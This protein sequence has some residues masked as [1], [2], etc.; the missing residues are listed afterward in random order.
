MKKRLLSLMLAVMM[1]LSILPAG[2]SA[3]TTMTGL[4]GAPA[5]PE[6]RMYV[7]QTYGNGDEE[8]HVTNNWATPLHDPWEARF[9]MYYPDGSTKEIHPDNMSRTSEVDYEGK[10]SAD[11][12][13]H[14]GAKVGPGIIEYEEVNAYTKGQKETYRVNVEI[15]LPELGVYD[16][17]PFNADSLVDPV[18]VSDTNNIFY[19]ALSPNMKAAGS[20][21]KEFVVVNDPNHAPDLST[22]ANIDIATDRTYA[23]VTV[24]AA[25]PQGDYHIRVR[26]ENDEGG[27]SG[28]WGRSVQ[29]ISDTPGLYFCYADRDDATESWFMQYDWVDAEKP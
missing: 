19:I 27:P 4:S 16:S 13:E 17:M 12:Y 15:G 8:I 21:M 23:K 6:L 7:R 5:T 10:T 26:V 28:T 14:I 29:I 3:V 22:V 25:Q 1:L 18:M 20:Y 24:T 2:A 11:W 9:F